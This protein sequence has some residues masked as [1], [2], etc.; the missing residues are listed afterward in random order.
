MNMRPKCDYKWASGTRKFK[1][2]FKTLE[3][4]M[5]DKHLSIQ[6]PPLR[7]LA[8]MWKNAAAQG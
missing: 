5:L 3:P 2:R 8:V 6:Y 1:I 4:D 7:G